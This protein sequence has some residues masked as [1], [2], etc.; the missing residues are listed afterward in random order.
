MRPRSEA[1]QSRFTQA[2]SRVL[3]ETGHAESS[4]AHGDRYSGVGE[5]Q[6]MRLKTRWAS[7]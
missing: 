2:K 1:V 6:G 5:I 3:R 4:E 7:C